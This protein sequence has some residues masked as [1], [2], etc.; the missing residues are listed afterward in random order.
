MRVG[1]LGPSGGHGDA[2]WEESAELSL[3]FGQG[4]FSSLH[5]G[6]VSSF[7]SPDLWGRKISAPSWCQ[8]QHFLFSKVDYK[9]Q[10]SIFV[11]FHLLVVGSEIS[12]YRCRVSSHPGLT[13]LFIHFPFHSIIFGRRGKGGEET[14]AVP[15]EG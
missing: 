15:L 4:H 6:S 2:R 11:I 9:S 13:E 5:P 3:G 1:C 10:T 7:Q 12:Y 8:K 14:L